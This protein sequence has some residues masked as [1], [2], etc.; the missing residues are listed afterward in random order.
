M[1]SYYLLKFLG[2]KK[3]DKIGESNIDLAR[4]VRNSSPLFHDIFIYKHSYILM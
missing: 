3:S 1:G 4:F 2:P